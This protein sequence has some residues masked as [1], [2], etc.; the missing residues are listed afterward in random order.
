MNIDFYKEPYLCN[1]MY[2]YKFKVFKKIHQEF[3]IFIKCDRLQTYQE[4]NKIFVV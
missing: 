2:A 3:K 4:S 1:K